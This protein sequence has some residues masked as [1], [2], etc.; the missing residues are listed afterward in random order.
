MNRLAI[1]AITVASLAAATPFWVM[2]E[3]GR[4]ETAALTVPTPAAWSDDAEALQSCVTARKG[5]R[6][7]A[8]CVGTVAET[9]LETR[10]DKTDPAC[11][12]REANGWSAVIDLYKARLE[13]RF[14]QGA[15]KSVKLHTDHVSWLADRARRCAGE[16][17]DA[18]AMKE[19]GRRALFLRHLVQEA[20]LL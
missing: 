2:A 8:N 12:R 20:G 5:G 11:L 18:C 7:A 9:C 15:P 14:G 1:A 4:I 13:Q 17:A 16:G 3:S 6:T 19:N 10:Q